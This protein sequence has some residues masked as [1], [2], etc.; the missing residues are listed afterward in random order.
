MESAMAKSGPK[1]DN[2]NWQDTGCEVSPT[3]LACPLPVCK[4]DMP[5]G[6]ATARAVM[7]VP[8]IRSLRAKGLND[9]EVARELGVSKRAIYRSL[10]GSYRGRLGDG[11]SGTMYQC[12]SKHWPC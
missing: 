1:P 11:E 6:V 12:V 9:T 3:C 7:R 2:V 4:Y 10:H 5:R 8:L